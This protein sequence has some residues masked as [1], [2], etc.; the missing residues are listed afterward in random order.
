MAQE[1]TAPLTAYTPVALYAN[2]PYLDLTV[3]TGVMTSTV[4]VNSLWTL[5]DLK[6]W[7][8]ESGFG[9]P[10]KHQILSQSVEAGES[11]HTELTGETTA[12]KDFNLRPGWPIYLTSSV[13]RCVCSTRVAAHSI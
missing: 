7:L 1:K 11:K 13:E 8:F 6:N 5:K 4:S 10:A 2:K 9:V 12:L 3:T